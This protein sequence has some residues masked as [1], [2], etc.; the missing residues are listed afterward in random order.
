V[1][2]PPPC[3]RRPQKQQQQRRRQQHQRS[4]TWRCRRGLG[5]KCASRVSCPSCQTHCIIPCCW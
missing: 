5:R 1:F 2:A 3:R 4:S